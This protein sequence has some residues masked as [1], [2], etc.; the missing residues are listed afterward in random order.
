MSG[1]PLA[2]KVMTASL[3]VFLGCTLLAQF[4]DKPRDASAV[5]DAG[6]GTIDGAIV[7][8]DSGSSI[9]TSTG[10]DATV[11]I[12]D[13]K[14]PPFTCAT[15]PDGTKV[16]DTSLRCC[17]HAETS[18]NTDS[19]CGACG[20]RCDT[21]HGHSCQVRG[22]NAMCTNCKNDGGGVCW[23]GC[24]LTYPASPDGVCVPNKPP[25]LCTVCDDDV[26]NQAAPGSSC[27]D[28]FLNGNTCRY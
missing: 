2:R 28:D 24:C 17:G 15:Q 23:T 1:T 6:A 4:D 12:P 11:D 27:H 21:A 7:D 5:V 9:D 19:N 14:P 26:C 20:I 10:V 3:S 18:V 8:L 16:P 25:F 22:G 13:T